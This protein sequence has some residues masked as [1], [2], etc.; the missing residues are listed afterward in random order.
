[1]WPDIKHYL[2]NIGDYP[3]DLYVTMVQENKELAADIKSFHPQA[4]IWVVE[5]RGYDVGPFVYFLHQIDLQQYDLILKIHS[6]TP[7]GRG[8]AHLGNYFLNRRKW[9]Y[10]L[11][12]GLLGSHNL[13]CRNIE[14]FK[15]D[16]K[17]GLVG[18]KYCLTS[19]KRNFKY[20]AN[21][22]PDAVQKLG[23][24]MP[25]KPVYI[26]GTMFMMRSSLLQI[27][28]D[29]FYLEDFEPTN[30]KIKDG[31]LA[32]VVERLFGIITSAQGY[33]IKGF[34]KN[35]HFEMFHILS[36]LRYQVYCKKITKNGYLLI[37]IC[38]IPVWHKKI[39]GEN[40]MMKQTEK[41]GRKVKLFAFIPIYSW[42][43]KGN[44]KVWKILGLPVVKRKIKGGGNKIKYYFCGIPL[45]K[46][47]KK[48]K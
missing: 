14:E 24:K 9:T 40:A 3:Y 22:L 8:L 6:K 30:G 38:K 48:Y 10:F 46:V 21:Q 7:L 34:D 36:W 42:K 5:N 1:M 17:L 11:F 31:T 41:C 18:T 28:K 32:H 44:K 47:V 20:V 15:S 43:V 4:K 23:Y 16:K 19:K 26:A 27:I 13:F 35:R 25:E 45:M 37:K 29:N 12:Q 2:Q 33:K 39:K